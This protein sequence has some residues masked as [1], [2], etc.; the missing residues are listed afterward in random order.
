MKQVSVC[1]RTSRGSLIPQGQRGIA[2]LEV[3]IAFFVL[4]IGLMGLASLQIKSLQ[5]NQGAYQRSQATVAANDILDR[6][7][8]NRKAAQADGYEVSLGSTSGGSGTAKDDLEEW[9]EFLSKNLPDGK[10]E[11]ECDADDICTVRIQWTDRFAT[12]ADPAKP[13]TEELV[14]SSQ[15]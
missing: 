15:M 5:F 13:V 10:G 3:L 11:I 1:K 7:R 9:L 2:L 8:L 14:I 6:M 12:S 4:S